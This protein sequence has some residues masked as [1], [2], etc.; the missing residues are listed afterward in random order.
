MYDIQKPVPIAILQGLPVIGKIYKVDCVKTVWSGIWADRW[1]PVIHK[2]S[3]EDYKALGPSALHHFHY[4]FRFLDEDLLQ[5][6]IDEDALTERCGSD[7]FFRFVVPRQ[8]VDR[9]P[10]PVELK[11]LRQMPEYPTT[12]FGLQIS[13]RIQQH[14]KGQLNVK[15]DCLRCP[16]RGTPLNGIEVKN[17]ILTCPAH[18]L[19][20]D[21]KTGKQIDLY[22]YPYADNR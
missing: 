10:E 8:S 17:N 12:G 5:W 14:Y 22:D 9:G 16:H 6:L 20:F 15:I 18:G 7:Q 1:F 3:H 13:R 21:V 2:K 11:C 4:D 19:K